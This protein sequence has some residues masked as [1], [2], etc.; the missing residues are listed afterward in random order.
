MDMRHR[1]EES[2][3]KIPK[4]AAGD[5]KRGVGGLVDIEFAVQYLQ[6][7]HSPEK[8]DIF[9]SNTLEAL[10]KLS[11]CEYVDAKIATKMGQNYCF[12]RQLESRQRLLLGKGVD[13]FPADKKRLEPLAWS[14]SPAISSPTEIESA[15]EEVKT[16][17]REMFNRILQGE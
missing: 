6:L 1:L 8:N 12:L 7:V 9:I 17:N 15:F 3:A 14:L 5:F 10:R 4:W 2:V 16:S 13:L 11:E